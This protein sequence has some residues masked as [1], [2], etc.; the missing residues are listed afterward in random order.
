MTGIRIDSPVAESPARSR[1]EIE[2]FAPSTFR[3]PTADPRP[4]T[5]ARS[6]SAAA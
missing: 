5:C 3:S 2:P 4:A 6:C 1:F